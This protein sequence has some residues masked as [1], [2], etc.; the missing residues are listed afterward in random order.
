MRLQLD[1]ARG[2]SCALPALFAG[3]GEEVT[4]LTPFTGGTT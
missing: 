1:A 3:A 4:T 2:E